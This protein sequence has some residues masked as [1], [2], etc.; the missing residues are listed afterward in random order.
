MPGCCEGY[1][2][3]TSDILDSSR[4]AHDAALTPHAREKTD[5][6]ECVDIAQQALENAVEFN[7]H[8]KAEHVRDIPIPAGGMS[9]EV[10]GCEPRELAKF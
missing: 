2:E 4:K 8:C 7:D 3:A 5:L 6:V 9:L 1:N 10:P